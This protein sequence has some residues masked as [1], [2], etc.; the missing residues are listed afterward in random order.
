VLTFAKAVVLTRGEV[1]D[2]T[3]EAARRAGLDDA[4]L[5]EIVG[6]V[7]VNVLTNYFNKTFAVEL[8]FPRVDPR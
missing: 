5:A 8:D 7:A 6:H 3:L 2:E 4:E 1:D